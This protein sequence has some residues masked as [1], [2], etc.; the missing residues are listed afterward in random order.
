[1]GQQLARDPL[2]VTQ[3]PEMSFP[4]RLEALAGHD[5]RC[6]VVSIEELVHQ[7]R[8]PVGAVR[9]VRYPCQTAGAAHTHL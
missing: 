8:Q 3:I 6:V 9:A 5:S 2:E 7:S 1:M 4:A